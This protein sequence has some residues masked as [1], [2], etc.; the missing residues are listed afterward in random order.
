M[1]RQQRLKR[2]GA[3]HLIPALVWGGLL[4]IILLAA[5]SSFGDAVLALCGAYGVV[6][7]LE[8]LFDL[9]PSTTAENKR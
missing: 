4:G 2:A 6:S 3:A 1:T 9:D 7:L 8:V 5:G